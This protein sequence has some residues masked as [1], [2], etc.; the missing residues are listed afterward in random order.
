MA[1]SSSQQ[2][3]FRPLSELLPKNEAGD[4]E[5]QHIVSALLRSDVSQ[6]DEQKQ[7]VVPTRLGPG[8]WLAGH[9]LC[10]CLFP[11][12]GDR[13]DYNRLFSIASEQLKGMEEHQRPHRLVVAQCP[14]LHH[15]QYK[16]TLTRSGDREGP[17]PRIVRSKWHLRQEKGFSA[18][19][20]TKTPGR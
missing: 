3:T 5:F 17:Q 6:E 14:Q 7:R 10:V 11:S 18:L 20:T 16:Q 1:T 8:V 19:T 12:Q 13:Y 9:T 15:R 4:A 2:A